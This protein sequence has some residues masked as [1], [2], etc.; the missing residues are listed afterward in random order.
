V[1]H[2]PVQLTV[3]IVL[4]LLAVSS[5]RTQIVPSR[6]P[7]SKPVAGIVINSSLNR[8]YVVAPSFWGHGDF[9]AVIDGQS[10]KIIATVPLA[11]GAYLPAINPLTNRIYIASCNSYKTPLRCFVAVLDGNDNKVIASIP[12]TNTEGNGIQGIAVDPVIDK[13][14]IANASDNVINVIDGHTNKLAETISING[15]SPYSIAI[16]PFNRRLYVPLGDDQLEVI[17]TRSDRILSTLTAGKANIFAGANLNT[18]EVLVIDTGFRPSATQDPNTEDFV[19]QEPPETA[20]V[21]VFS[22]QDKLLARIQVGAS[23]NA[24]D[25]D[26]VTNLSFVINTSAHTV[27]VIDGKTRRVATTIRNIEGNFIAVNAKTGKVYIAGS[28][29][30]TVIREDSR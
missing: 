22:H 4:N 10:D 14:Y 18:G 19:T 16:D 5:A 25:I 6:I 12:V 7:F 20:S 17:D 1:H 2:R 8:V 26:T 27:T 11:T 29:G 28:H 21:L 13:V 24:L 9:L 3:A 30:V 23:P 15:E